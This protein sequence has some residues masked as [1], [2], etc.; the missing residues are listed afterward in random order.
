ML[1]LNFDPFAEITTKRLLLRKILPT[2][3]SAVYELRTNEQVMQF[4][5]KEPLKNLDEATVLVEKIIKDFN[6]NIGITLCICLPPNPQQ[7]IG[8]IGLWRIE[9]ENYRAEIGY[10][11]HPKY[12]NKGFMQEAVKAI[13]EYGFTQLKLHSIMANINPH[14]TASAALLEKTNFVREAYFKEDYY[15][16]GKFLDT[17]IYSKLNK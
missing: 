7:L 14:N 17:A 3:V 9:K 8:T 15:F 10:M 4:I 1:E 6:D 16:R 5:D 11:L 13:I 2:D 12:W